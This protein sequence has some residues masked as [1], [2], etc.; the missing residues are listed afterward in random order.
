MILETLVCLSTAIY[1]E[2]RGEPFA[3]QLAVA[4]TIMNRVEDERFPDT[5]CGVV[6]QGPT[7]SW[8]EGFPVRHQCQFSFY[9]DG[10][11][12]EPTDEHAYHVAELIATAVLEQRAHDVSEGATH[13]HATYVTPS[14]AETKEQTVRIN[15]HIFYRWRDTADTLRKIERRK[16]GYYTE[17]W[18]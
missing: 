9:C 10:K 11:S 1:F 13:Y 5:V 12:D 18:D 14:W 15:N 4:N 2:A 8:T 16:N 17:Y 7:Y 3:G 6:T